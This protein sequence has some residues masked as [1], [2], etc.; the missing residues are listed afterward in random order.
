MKPFRILHC[1]IGNMN[2]GGIENVIMQIYRNIDRKRFQFDFV[3]HEKEN[4]YAEE[5]V[6]LGGIIY[7]IPYISVDY[8][9]H[10]KAF[11]KILLEHPEYKVIHIHTTYSIMYIDA[12]IAKKLGRKVIIHS[13]NSSARGKRKWFHYMYKKKLSDIADYRIACS[14]I[15]AAWMFTEESM[16]KNGITIWKNSVD[17]EKF[18]FNLAAREEIRIKYGYNDDNILIGNIARLSYQKNQTLL[19]KIFA[20]LYH[21]YPNFRLI[22]VGDGED[23][24]ML[25]K[26]VSKFNLDKV[27]CFTGQQRPE[28]FLMAMDIFVLTSRYEG[29][30]IS[31]L[32]AQA[33]GLP[34]VAPNFTDKIIKITDAFYEIN[35]YNNINEWE[36]KII[37]AYSVKMD[38]EKTFDIVKDSGFDIVSLKNNVNEFYDKLVKN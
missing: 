36:D 16:E 35:N 31:L 19:I 25:K 14:D 18:Q 17:L 32:E 26:Q 2:V 27:V 13:H 37:S 30:G 8:K 5:I 6:S 20:K 7:Q 15:A 24:N 10:C 12:K 28:K 11:E 23:K 29:F 21:N 34:V 3:V 1:P 38:R 22:I 33:A 9:N 4:V